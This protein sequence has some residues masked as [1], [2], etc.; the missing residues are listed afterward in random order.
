MSMVWKIP[1][2]FVSFRTHWPGKLSH[3]GLVCT[4]FKGVLP[5]FWKSQIPL[6]IWSDL[7]SDPGKMYVDTYIFVCAYNYRT[8]FRSSEPLHK[9][10]LLLLETTPGPQ[11]EWVSLLGASYVFFQRTVKAACCSCLS[12]VFI[13]FPIA[14]IIVRIVT[15]LMILITKVYGVLALCQTYFP[16]WYPH[17]AK[18]TVFIPLYRLD[19]RGTGKLLDFGSWMSPK[20]PVSKAWLTALGTFGRWWIL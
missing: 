11:D 15:L 9:E 14:V 19:K 7:E 12:F 8:V 2:G 18:G 17:P 20:G 3:P 10:L 5:Q 1:E 16:I 4:G 6:G 13:L